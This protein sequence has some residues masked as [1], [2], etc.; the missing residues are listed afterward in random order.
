MTFHELVTT[1]WGFTATFIGATV[2]TISGFVHLKMSVMR[3]Q[4]DRRDDLN[5]LRGE[6]EA[7]RQLAVKQREEDRQTLAHQQVEVQDMLREMREDI[8][9]LLSRSG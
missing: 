9:K 2:G 5:R 1:Y 6:R 7:D 4:Q 3:L 8:K